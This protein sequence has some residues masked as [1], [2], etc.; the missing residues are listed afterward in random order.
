MQGEQ[1]HCTEAPPAE[2]KNRNDEWT[3]LRAAYRLGN[4]ADP[5]LASRCMDELEQAAAREDTHAEIWLSNAIVAFGSEVAGLELLRRAAEPHQ[6]VHLRTL[7][8]DTL[9]DCGTVPAHAEQALELF[10]GCLLH[11]A[12]WVRY[13]GLT[14]LEQAGVLVRFAWLEYDAGVGALLAE[15]ACPLAGA[16]ASKHTST[17][18]AILHD[19][20]P[21]IVFSALSALFYTAADPRRWQAEI[22]AV[23]TSHEHPMVSW[24][25]AEIGHMVRNG[26]ESSCGKHPGQQAHH[27]L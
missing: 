17:I 18:A 14:G 20:S 16:S 5:V 3:V 4:S 9:M 6:S 27:R 19:Q 10:A 15:M 22:E 26:L 11:D 24:K 13:A 1:N 23:A 8:L 25:A 21:F 2:Q 7:L 12:E